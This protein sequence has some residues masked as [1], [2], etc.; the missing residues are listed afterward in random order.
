MIMLES[1]GVDS[2]AG[3]TSYCSNGF[4]ERGRLVS[5]VIFPNGP[6]IRLI[7]EM[8][9]TC[10]GTIT[11]FTFSGRMVNGDLDPTIQIYRDNNSQPGEYYR[12]GAD[13]RINEI[14]CVGGF[15]QVFAGVFRCNL[16]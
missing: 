8:N 5:D 3:E 12:T 9:F 15:T 7:P 13:I 10:N 6:A 4:P 16:N 14:V 2:V 11:G 1:A